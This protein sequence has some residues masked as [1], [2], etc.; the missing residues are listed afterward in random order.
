[1]PPFSLAWLQLS[2]QKSRLI[3]SIIG[4]TFSVALMFITLGLKEG[5][6]E[7]SVTIH[8]TL[9][10]DLVILSSNFQSF[11]TI[12]TNPFPR[13]ILYNI[14]AIKGIV[15]ANPFYVGFAGFK[16][17]DLSTK[18]NIGV[19][20]FNPDKPAFNLREINQQLSIIKTADTF[21]FDRLSRPEYGPIVD[22]FKKLE[23]PGSVITEL[24]DIRIKIGGFFSIGGGVFSADGLLIT[25]DLNYSRLFSRPLEKVHLGLVVLEAGISPEVMIKKV[26]QRL[27]YQVKVVTKE[28]FLNMEKDYWDR[29]TPIGVIFKMLSLVGF[30]FGGVIVYQIMFTQISDYLSVYATFKA[31]GYTNKYII[32][33]V[34]QEA[35]LMSIIGYIP[36]LFGSLYLY[37][38][39]QQQ[40]RLPMTFTLSKTL[41]VLLLT[42]M[43]CF[44]AALMSVIKLR[45][46]DPADLFK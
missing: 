21:L 8:K 2:H 9:Q 33:L 36:G 3:V 20:A 17:P 23:K 40:T 37:D 12:H 31:M 35:F 32:I 18:K 30:V 22:K 5:L 13:R 39:I 14:S 38:F 43:M 16:N 26:A 41:S 4:V 34:L 29:A 10:A 42:I 6:F 24:S 1:M 28:E 44:L 19:V 7:D 27:P 11:W 45:D 46:A 25:S 15:S